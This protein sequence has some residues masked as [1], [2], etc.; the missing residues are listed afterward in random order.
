MS[1]VRYIDKTREYYRAEG[2]D[3]PY[4]WPHFE[5][6]PFAELGKPLDACRLTLVSTCDVAVKT[7]DAEPAA[8]QCLIGSVYSIDAA[9]PADRLFSR[10]EHFDRHATNLDDVNSFFPVA[11][12][13]ELAAEGRI[14]GVAP[15]L[16]GVYMGY[17][18]R[19]T[20][21][22]DGPEVLRRCREDGVDAVILT[23]I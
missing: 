19:R 17:S 6:V 3:E 14:G 4:R 7:E 16:H 2:Y 15:R 22:I 23:P 5:A 1:H 8:D 10:Q 18:Q 13:H 12:L 21:E 9:T 11:R 20:L